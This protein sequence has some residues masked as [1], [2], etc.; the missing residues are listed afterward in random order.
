MYCGCGNLEINIRCP[1]YLTTFCP[2][3]SQRAFV[4]IPITA[5]RCS[6]C[7]PTIDLSLWVGETIVIMIYVKAF[8]RFDALPA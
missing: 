3:R 7:M 8:H 1:F 2:L 4:L 6:V 5:G